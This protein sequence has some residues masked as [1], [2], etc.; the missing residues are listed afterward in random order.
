[1]R[2]EELRRPEAP[3][4][5]F[6]LASLATGAVWLNVRPSLLLGFYYSNEMLALTHTLTLGFVTSLILGVFHR[7]A[8][9]SIF[10][11]PRSRVWSRVQFWLYVVGVL[12]MIFHFALSEWHGL[13]WSAF[14][15][16]CAALVQL[17]NWSGVW[18]V[19]FRG[20][21]VA[22]FVACAHVYFVLA[23]TL[24]TLM[25]LAKGRP[26]W[27]SLPH[28]VFVHNLYAHVHLAALGWVANMIFG[29]HLKLWPRTAGRRDWLPV[30]FLLLQAG[31]LGMSV[32]WLFGFGNRIPFA[33][34]V[35]AAVI[36]QAWGP[37]LGWIS[38]RAREWELLPMAALLAVIALGVALAC[39]WPP[40][41]DPLR[42]RVQFAFAFI[43]LWGWIVLSIA[44]FAFKLFPMW[45]WQ[46]RFQKDLGTSD[47]PAMRDLYS[48]RLF[49]LTN[50]SLFAGTAGAA[51]AISM[52]WE[53]PLRLSLGILL[54]GVAGFLAN[55]FRVARWA[56]FNR[57]YTP[58]RPGGG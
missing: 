4:I 3:Y 46:E 26:G 45:V 48:R 24:G 40:E 52:A 13:A 22:R 17:F 8:P 5:L 49:A 11:E 20:E 29:F 37:V 31:V 1:M 51:F 27:V 35:A 21:W 15:V 58:A 38:R 43:A 36:W 55:F 16:W 18:A 28:G 14:L 7:L 33:L 12:G 9:M 56:L 10:V 2:A 32:T 50:L 25:G 23:A 6:A 41:E 54:I 30:R 53:W 47:V 42:L 34:L 44:V 57:P 39:G 19:A